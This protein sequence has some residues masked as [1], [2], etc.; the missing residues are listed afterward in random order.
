MFAAVLGQVQSGN[1][2][3]LDAERL[4]ENCEQ[5]GHEDDEEVTIARGCTGLDV[6]GIVAR[7]DVGDSNEKARTDESCIF[8]KDISC[9]GVHI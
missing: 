7:V 8:Y 2:A 1:A 4:E 3:E 5:V 6:S 9:S